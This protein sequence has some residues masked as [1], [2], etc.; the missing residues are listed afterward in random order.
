MTH[1]WLHSVE[2]KIAINQTTSLKPTIQL[3]RWLLVHQLL[4]IAMLTAVAYQPAGI[5][6]MLQHYH[7]TYKW[8][9]TTYT[10]PP[11]E[12]T[13]PRVYRHTQRRWQLCLGHTQQLQE[14]M[15]ACTVYVTT[16]HDTP[17]CTAGVVIRN[18]PQTT[19]CVARLT[20]HRYVNSP[21][22]SWDTLQWASCLNAC[23]VESHWLPPN[24]ARVFLIRGY[25]I[26]VL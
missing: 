18:R 9:P 5:L 16:L 26:R 7:I 1:T 8:P 4:S 20:T 17:P 23:Q 3:P 25:L 21:C 10:H 19:A 13:Q 14:C 22:L 11:M 15:T 2:S 6:M 24:R 12:P